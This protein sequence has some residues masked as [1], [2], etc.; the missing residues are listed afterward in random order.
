MSTVRLHPFTGSDPNGE[1][2]LCLEDLDT[3]QRSDLT[4][5]QY[6]MEE[7]EFVYD[8]GRPNKLYKFQGR[9]QSRFMDLM[10]V[11][12]FNTKRFIIFE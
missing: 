3:N 12:H 4:S 7:L 2:H 11:I 5:V 1:N 10:S 6:S 8:I 9:P